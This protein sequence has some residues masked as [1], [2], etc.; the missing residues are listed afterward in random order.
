M[1]YVAKQNLGKVN[2]VTMLR[3]SPPMHWTHGQLGSSNKDTL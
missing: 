2:L 1:I 3:S